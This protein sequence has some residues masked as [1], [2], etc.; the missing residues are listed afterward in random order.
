MLHV[1]RL[2]TVHPALAHFT[3]GGLPLIVIAYGIAV[4]RRSPAWTLV[5]DAA[6]V[7]TAA[8]T[9]ATGTF[10]LVSNAIVPWPGGIE[11][12]RWTHLGFGIATTVLLA[13]LAVLRLAFRRS[14]VPARAPVFAAAII[15]AGVAA[16][17]GWVGGEV[18]VFHSGMAVRAAGD[19][20]FAPPVSDSTER[21]KDFLGAMRQVRASWGAIN[22]RL[23]WMLVQHPRDEDFQRIEHD[24]RRMQAL[25]KVMADEGA[26]YGKA[27]DTIASMAQTLG[28]D[29]DDIAEAA[30]KKSLQDIAHGVG[31]ASSHCADCHEETRWH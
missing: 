30:K 3:I 26:K 17:T 9:L 23:A 6:L 15:V 16:F 7:V 21:P 10:G 22:T 5:A 13:T 12:W 19:G 1:V 4:W 29:A 20:A 24:A 25:T 11:S 18:L 8:L 27:A 2:A 31:E 28:G 14:D